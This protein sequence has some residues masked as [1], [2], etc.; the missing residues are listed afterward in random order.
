[1]PGIFG[2]FRKNGDD[3]E[4]GR[5]LI[6]AMESK[7]SHNPDYRSE[8]VCND[9]WAIGNSG[10]PCAGEQRFATDSTRGAAAFSGY[11]YGWKNTEERYS[12]PT[13]AKAS[14]IL[15][16]YITHGNRL[17]EMIDGSFNAVAIDPNSSRAVLCND[18]FGHRQ[19][20][21]YEDD[22][23]FIFS[24]EFKAIMAYGRFTP[25]LDLDAVADYFNFGYL[26]G[27]KTF[28]KGIRILRGGDLVAFESRQVTFNKY[29]DYSYPEESR[30]S[31]AELVEEADS[32]YREVIKKQLQ[33][34]G[35]VI[36]PLSGG[37][38][39]R[40]ISAHAVEAGAEPFAFTHGRKGCSDHRIA[41][42]VARAIGISNYKF[43]EIDPEWAVDYAEKFVY[44]TEGMVDSSPSI[45]FGIAREYGLPAADS[46]FL[47]GIY[48]GPGNFGSVFITPGD[49]GVQYDFERKVEAICRYLGFENLDPNFYALFTENIR[50]HF[51]GNF[52][53]SIEME[54]PKFLGVSDKYYQQKDV[55]FLKNNIGRYMNQV[56]CNRFIWHDHFALADDRLVDFYIKLPS[57]MHF[58]RE[59]MVAYFK[60]IFPRL[61]KIPYQKTGVDLYSEPPKWKIKAK[62]YAKRAEYYAERLSKGRLRFYDMDSYIHPNQAYRARRKIRDF[63]E[64]ILLDDRTIGRGFFEKEKLEALLK[65]QRE[66]GNSFY[67]LS[68]LLAFELFNRLFIDK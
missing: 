4:D 31:T 19:L 36:I 28:L 12:S 67:D 8:T 2:F 35:N 42:E 38:D 63:Y 27:D 34:A 1:M 29:W 64:Q 68:Y 30:Q 59:F 37:L 20:Y 45:L 26:M 32:I 18:R 66:G 23:I 52:K 11:I 49:I 61:A 41:R 16:I 17:P 58:E 51:L 33:Y 44:M 46:V 3:R 54:F 60:T 62:K 24:T 43:I 15:D 21:Y 48:G 53:T 39:S 9:L 55:F 40:F 50:S 14:R 22:S 10:L 47:N 13:T 25:E 56:D 5:R 65:R 6:A 57:R 7:L